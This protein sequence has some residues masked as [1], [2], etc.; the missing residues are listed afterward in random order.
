MWQRTAAPT[1]PGTAASRYPGAPNTGLIFTPDAN[2]SPLT[3]GSVPVPVV[4]LDPVWLGDWARLIA[5]PSHG[6]VR[7]AV[8]GVTGK[9]QPRVERVRHEKTLS[10]GDRVQRFRAAASPEAVRLAAHIAVSTPALPVMRLIQRTMLHGSKPGHLAEVLLSGLLRPIDRDH[11]EF[12]DEDVRK[13]LLATLPRSESWHAINV[14]RRVSTEIERHAGAAMTTFPA[15]LEVRDQARNRAETGAGSP[16]ALI[17]STAVHALS[18]LAVP[19]LSVPLQPNTPGPDAKR[20]VRTSRTADSPPYFYLSYAHTPPQEGFPGDPDIWVA[21]FF[22]DLCSHIMQLTNLPPGTRPGFMDRELRRGSEWPAQLAQAL[23]TCRVFVPLYS[24][25]Y[26]D[27]EHCGREWFAFSRRALNHAARGAGHAETIIPALWVPV[28][29][30]M[31]PAAARSIQFDHSQL[32]DRYSTHGFYGIIKLSRYRSEYEEAVY[33]LARRIVM[34]G[35][36]V[37]LSPAQPTDFEFLESAFGSH[38]EGQTAPR[39]IRITVVAPTI[40]G[41]PDGRS[42]YYYGRTA[43][44]WNP[45]RPDSV[46]SLTDYAADLTRSLGYQSDIGT[47]NEH[48]EGLLADD[49]PE[50]PSLLLID[51]WATM[52]PEIRQLLHR[53]DIRSTPWISIMV[54]WNTSD[55]ETISAQDKLRQSL[56][57]TLSSDPG[58]VDSEAAPN[59]EL[60]IP[61]LEAFGLALP[62]TIRATAREYL[63]RAQAY[64][65][66]GPVIERPRLPLP[67]TMNTGEPETRA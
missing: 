55:T 57:T 44:E 43:R 6:T 39:R 61:T 38:T 65:P 36:N 29:P 60:Q 3:H 12:I 63:E 62:G 22:N 49:T 1:I 31:L 24:R 42:A 66:P 48:T 25:R 37:R 46:Q 35:Q 59:L 54:P 50:C 41:L 19:V 8:T 34:V 9:P 47:L 13:E 53:L 51:P 17:S 18:N 27:S 52:N 4:E 26:F 11:Y 45:Y 64:P 30:A 21:N 14:L 5:D 15:L 40:S 10:V 20:P 56:Y 28:A 23:A 33:E 2:S 67:D 16:F 58:S 7:T 32:G